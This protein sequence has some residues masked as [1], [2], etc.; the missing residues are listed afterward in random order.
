MKEWVIKSL[1][2]RINVTKLIERRTLT[3]ETVTVWHVLQM[4]SQP[5][6]DVTRQKLCGR[7][8]KRAWSKK[9]G[10][11]WQHWIHV[12]DP[13]INRLYEVSPH[14]LFWHLLWSPFISHNPI[15]IHFVVPTFHNLLMVELRHRPRIL[16]RLKFDLIMRH[17]VVWI[18]WYP[19]SLHSHFPPFG[20]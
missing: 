14:L 20:C 16:D 1:L 12:L 19:S 17:P 2:I 11:L 5:F 7:W 6:I 13:S 4:K 9:E 3:G 8:D 18:C 10:G 15:G